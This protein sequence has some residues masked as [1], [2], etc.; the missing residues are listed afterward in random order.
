MIFNSAIFEKP[1]CKFKF[2]QREG[3]N[4]PNYFEFQNHSEVLT[5]YKEYMQYRRDELTY[6]IDGLVQEVDD[7]DAQKELGYQPNGLIP[8]F[9][10]SIKFDSMGSITPLVSVRW[11]VGMTGKII[12]TGIFKPV[13]IMGVTV[14]KATFHNFEFIENLINK[15]NLK[16]GSECIIIRAGDV[17]P[18]MIGVKTSGD[19]DNI[20]IP[21]NCPVCDSTLNRFSV[22]LVCE[23]PDCDAKTHGII[24]NM[25]DTLDIKGLSGKFAAKVVDTYDISTI[26]ELMR[27]SLDDLENLPGFGKKSAQKAHDAI[28]SVTEVSPEQFFAMLNIPNQGV[29]VF[30]NLFAQFPMEKLL[31][32]NFKPDDILDTKGIAEKSANAIHQG[33]Q[34]NLDRIRENSEWFIIIKKKVNNDT[35]SHKSNMVGKSFCITGT[36]NN[37]TRKEYETKIKAMGGKTGSVTK[38]LDYL[39]TNDDDT[40]SSKMKKTLEINAKNEN[41]GIDK[42]ILIITENDLTELME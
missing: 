4:V 39:V 27:L 9:A 20:E 38:K 33:I 40:S 24:T 10:T 15:E 36:L 8:K 18:K 16:I 25:F 1:S 30:E 7:F 6:D 31:D 3:F 42:R 14:E 12:P 26:D 34:D 13:D 5:L 29:R 2:L 17:I 11:T 22:E 41:D 35:T 37:G 32:E 21:T 19:G 23:N 28:H